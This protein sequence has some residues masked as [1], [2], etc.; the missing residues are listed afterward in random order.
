M[1]RFYIVDC[2]LKRVP[3]DPS[4]YIDEANGI[5]TVMPCSPGSSFDFDVCGCGIIIEGAGDYCKYTCIEIRV[6]PLC[7]YG[8]ISLIQN[9]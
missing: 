3:G 2:H 4:S 1:L 7:T 9:H 5:E 8:F 6:N